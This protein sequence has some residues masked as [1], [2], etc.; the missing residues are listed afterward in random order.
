MPIPTEWLIGP[1]AALAGAIVILA[2]GAGNVWVYGK[3]HRDAIERERASTQQERERAD[4]AERQRDRTI[5][6]MFQLLQTTRSAQ[7]TTKEAVQAVKE[8]PVVVLA[9]PGGGAPAG[10]M[11]EPRR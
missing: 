8:R 4:R 11:S 7:E 5:D 9:D 2:A 1:F 6:A 10:P 3:S